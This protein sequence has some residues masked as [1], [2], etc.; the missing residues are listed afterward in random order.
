MPTTLSTGPSVKPARQTGPPGPGSAT[1][2]RVRGY[3]SS[4]YGKAFVDVYD[5]WYGSISDVDATVRFLAGLVPAGG[6]ILELGVG[7]GRLALPL[8]ERGSNEGFG[9]WGI[10]SSPEMLGVLRERDP[11]GLVRAVAGDMVADI[12]PDRFGGAV[13]L[14]FAAYN[15]L[16]NLST[17]A[18]QRA[19]FAAVARLLRPGGRFVVEAFVPAVGAESEH[20]GIR[21]MTAERVVLSASRQLDDQRSEGHFIE[22]TESGGVRLRPWAIRWS[23]IDQLDAMAGAAE[24]DLERR[25]GGFDGATFDDDSPRHVSVYRNRHHEQSIGDAM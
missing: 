13:D 14:V 24:L 11:A 22:L 21:S 17:E 9:V 18:S 7:T 23:T 5:D 15:T 1:V 20:V 2:R 16:F 25:H 10:D 12:T 19:C 3:D 6:T 8:A 4:S